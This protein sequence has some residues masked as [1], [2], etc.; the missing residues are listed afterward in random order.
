MNDI[1]K[2]V[3]RYL[4]IWNE[5]DPAVRAARIDEVWTAEATYTDPL[6]SVRGHEAI[7]G[8]IGGVQQQFPGLAL[9]LAGDVDAHHDVARFSWE[10]VPAGATEPLVIGFDVATVGPDGRLTAVYGFLDKVPAA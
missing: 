6:A 9:T 7:N 5:P 3:E 1:A 10:L 8:M 2:T 4:E